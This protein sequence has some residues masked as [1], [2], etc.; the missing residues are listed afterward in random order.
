MNSCGN[1]PQ[2]CLT[3]SCSGPVAP[4]QNTDAARTGILT[5]EMIAYPNPTSGKLNV[6]FTALAKEKY[7]LKLTDLVGRVMMSMPSTSEEG[8]NLQELDLSNYAKGMYLLSIEKEGM[9][10]QTIRIVVE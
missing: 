3:V 1:G 7:T 2:R 10:P 8:A 4:V 9:E 5:S 6:S